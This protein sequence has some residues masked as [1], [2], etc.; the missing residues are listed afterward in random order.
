MAC[1][2]KFLDLWRIPDALRDDPSDAALLRIRGR[3]TKDPSAFLEK[4]QDLYHDWDGQSD[5]LLEFKDGRVFERHS[6]PQIVRGKEWGACWGFRDVTQQ[7]RAQEEL[8]RAKEAAEAASRA[9]SEFLANMSHEIRTP[10]NGVIGMTGLL[11]D[12]DLTR[13]SG[14]TPR[15]CAG[16]AK[17][18]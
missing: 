11:L 14:S 3:A 10:M 17:R 6:E 9:K 8:A 5:D 2:G 15:P 4:V 7:R 18:C 1:N 13:S 16:P 12:T